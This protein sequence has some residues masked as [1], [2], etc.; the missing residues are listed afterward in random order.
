MPFQFFVL[1]K[2][3]Q[4]TVWKWITKLKS[5][6]DGVCPRYCVVTPW[7]RSEE[8]SSTNYWLCDEVDKYAQNLPL[9]HVEVLKALKKS[10]AK[11]EPYYDQN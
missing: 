3:T 2:F 9:S 1:W 4:A 7:N 11:S 6:T 8:I 5:P 10:E